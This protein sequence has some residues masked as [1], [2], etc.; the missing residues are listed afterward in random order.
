MTLPSV[1]ALLES[2]V[3][4]AGL[5]PPAQLPMVSAVLNYAKYRDGEHAWML[6]RFVVPAARYEELNPVPSWPLSILGF[7]QRGR[8]EQAFR[9]PLNTTENAQ[10]KPP[11]PPRSHN[12]SNPSASNTTELK[13]ENSDDI[14]K[15]LATLTP[16]V[17]AYFE[18]PITTDPEPLIQ[19][20]AQNGARAKVRTGGITPTAF[21]SVGDLSRFILRCHEYNVPFK[22]TAGLHHPIRGIHPL[23]YEQ[24]SPRHTMFGFLNVFLAAAFARRGLAIHEIL[25]EESI[26][27]FSFQPDGIGWR[28]FFLTNA[29]IVSARQHFAIAF[30]SCSFEEP[31][32]DL[33]D[34]RLL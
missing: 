22:A 11:A 21:P 2:I 17:T 20:L 7:E 14:H 26:A 29:D 31:V 15:A 18:I 3:D 19:T 23:T 34:L 28:D 1:R 30:G 13:A 4:Y 8:V 24:D 10:V 12:L 16:G 5:F 6:G 33:Q 32:R 9:L 25:L 27:A